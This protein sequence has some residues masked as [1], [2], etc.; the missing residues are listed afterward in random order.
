MRKVETRTNRDDK[1]KLTTWSLQEGRYQQLPHLRLVI[2]GSL[3]FYN[4]FLRDPEVN[5]CPILE[6]WFVVFAHLLQH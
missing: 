1:R 3:T 2:H 4:K 6:S 5:N